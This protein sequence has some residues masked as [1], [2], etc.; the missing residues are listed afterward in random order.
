MGNI[1]TNFYK[2][3]QCEHIVQNTIFV[4]EFID[5]IWQF[6]LSLG[7]PDIGC[8]SLLIMS[9]PFS[10]WGNGKLSL[11]NSNT[12]NSLYERKRYICVHTHAYTYLNMHTSVC[13]CADTHTRVCRCT[14]T[15]TCVHAH[16]YAH[17]CIHTHI[18]TYTNTYTHVRMHTYMHIHLHMDTRTRTYTHAHTCMCTCIRRYHLRYVDSKFWCK[19]E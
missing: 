9:Y 4:S 7:I 13:I 16:T 3:V 6:Q 14:H 15:Y 11:P 1:H 17:A 8:S 10:D 12:Q 5:L 2:K 18:R 19:Q